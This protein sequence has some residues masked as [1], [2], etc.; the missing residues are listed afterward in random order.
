MKQYQVLFFESKI[1]EKEKRIYL[2]LP[3]SYDKTEQH[4]SVLYMHD[5]QNLFDTKTAYSGETWQIMEHYEKNPDLP[6]LIIVGIEQ[7]QDRSDELVPY[8]FTFDDGEKAGGKADKYLDFITK[9][10]KPYIDRKYRTFKSPKNTAIMGA[11]FGGVNS[12]YAALKYSD[13]FSRIGCISNAVLFDGFFKQ[14]LKDTKASTF[15]NIRKIYIDT[16]TNESE[17]IAHQ[18]L[19]LQNNQLL[20]EALEKKVPKENLRFEIIDGG[21]HHETDWS[22]RIENI[23]L[24][25][26]DK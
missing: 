1:L 25:L 18:K 9:E 19:Y 15:E 11:S 26:F 10:L 2:Y 8:S 20:V 12:Y 6:E 4:Y 17:K 16:G 22:K 7:G 14:L 23:I 5:G 24:F 21:K 3:K 13:F